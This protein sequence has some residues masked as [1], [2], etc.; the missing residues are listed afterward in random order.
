MT[1]N[2]VNIHSQQ[3]AM[4]HQ[5]VEGGNKKFT[6]GIKKYMPEVKCLKFKV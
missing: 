4:L 1:M 5:L 2:T 6:A 3:G